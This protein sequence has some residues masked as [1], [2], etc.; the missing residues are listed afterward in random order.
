[1]C[2]ARVIN[3]LFLYSC[4]SL[5]S[6]Q[7]K[8]TQNYGP[9]IHLLPPWDVFFQ[10]QTSSTPNFLSS[11]QVVPGH[12]LSVFLWPLLC[13]VLATADEESHSTVKVWSTASWFLVPSVRPYPRLAV[14]AL[15]LEAI[16]RVPKQDLPTFFYCHLDSSSLLIDHTCFLSY[17]KKENQWDGV[18]AIVVGLHS[19]SFLP[20]QLL[21]HG[22][23]KTCP[24]HAFPSAEVSIPLL[25]RWD[26]PARYLHH[27]HLEHILHIHGLWGTV[28]Q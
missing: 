19:P 9:N 16:D 26:S 3:N 5:N 18:R 4:F 25:V 22:S 7:P 2:N 11:Q 24:V 23:F 6:S 21:F 8:W 28:F 14:L 27:E 20:H 15:S 12:P 17:W 13:Y 10:L 1:M